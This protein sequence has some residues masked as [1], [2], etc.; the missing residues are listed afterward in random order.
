MGPLGMCRHRG[1]AQGQ[2]GWGREAGAARAQGWVRRGFGLTWATHPMACG[3]H[4]PPGA[5]S[6]DGGPEPPRLACWAGRAVRLRAWTMHPSWHP[7]PG[8]D[9]GAPRPTGSWPARAPAAS[10]EGPRALWGWW[11]GDTRRGQSTATRG[12]GRGGDLRPC[13]HWAGK[14]QDE[15]QGWAELCW[16]K[17]WRWARGQVPGPVGMG[18]AGPH[19]GAWGGPSAWLLRPGP[20]VAPGPLSV[21]PA[22]RQCRQTVGARQSGTR[23]RIWNQCSAL[24]R[25]HS[26]GGP[27]RGPGTAQ[28]Q[29]GRF[30]WLLQK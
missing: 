25:L 14:G 5:Q 21:P 2:R 4:S 3:C 23:P 13:V 29:L 24:H 16:A 8:E 26:A 27:S 15:A 28:C 30:L 22:P 18:R 1:G 9:K 17:G 7:T 19:P 11:G 6:G 12:G 20:P 10:G